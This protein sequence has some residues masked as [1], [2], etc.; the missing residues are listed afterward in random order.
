MPS[1]QA[2]FF[3]FEKRNTL[4]REQIIQKWV[5]GV[6]AELSINGY[7][8]HVANYIM[9]WM[10]CTELSINGCSVHVAKSCYG[11]SVTRIKLNKI[12]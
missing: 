10:Q 6:D 1:L 7:S 11:Y 5:H 4:K 9:Q 12:K 3:I 2:P 8:V